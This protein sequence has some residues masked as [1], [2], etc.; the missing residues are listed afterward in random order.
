MKDKDTRWTVLLELPYF[1]NISM[2]VIDPMHNLYM[3]VTKHIISKFKSEGIL[4][5]KRLKNIQSRIAKLPGSARHGK[6][7]SKIASNMSNFT[8]QVCT[9]CL[10][11]LIISHLF[12][13]MEDFCHYIFSLGI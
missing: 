10:V 6:M 5:E 12:S 2:H 1:D 3:G 11:C 4:T 7:R 9:C 8:A 13:G